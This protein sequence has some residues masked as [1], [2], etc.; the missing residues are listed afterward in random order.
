MVFQST[1]PVAIGMAFTDW[2]FA[3]ASMVACSLALVGGLLAIF[4]LQFR[5]RFHWR[6]IVAWAGLFAAFVVYIVVAA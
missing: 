6:A 2:D 3:P 4:E 1:L 5:R